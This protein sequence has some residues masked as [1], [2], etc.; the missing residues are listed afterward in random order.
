MTKMIITVGLPGSGKTTF[1]NNLV[2]LEL[3]DNIS[4][5]LI[6]T[7]D[8]LR[9]MA[10]NNVFIPKVTEQKI[11]TMRNDLIRGALKRQQNVIVADTNLSRSGNKELVKI[12]KQF[13]SNVR[14][15][16][17]DTHVDECVV[18]DSLREGFS[19]VGKDIIYNMH[20]KYCKNGLPN[21]DDLITEDAVIFSK[22]IPNIS[23][24]KAVIFDIDG[25][26]ASHEGIRSPYDYSKVLLDTPRKAVVQTLID[27]YTLNYEIIIMSGRDGSCYPDTKAWLKE[28][29][30]VLNENF[31]LFMRAP[32]DKRQDRIV[33]GELFDKFIRND[34]NVIKVYDDRTSVI[35]LW[36]DELEL[37]AF[38]VNWGDF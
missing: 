36:R 3:K 20:N 18:R 8:N 21:F 13:G 2:A 1:A 15:E 19:K 35:K 4:P 38:Q 6:V 37:D 5:S 7:R 31:S 16:Y 26:L 17:F 10:F 24:R 25:T 14:F 29:L 11:V 23:K 28:H 27:C 22:Y 9:T 32:G 30:S 12:A 34:F 33:K